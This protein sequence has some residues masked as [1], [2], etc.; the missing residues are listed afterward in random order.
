MNVQLVTVSI[1]FRGA[2]KGSPWVVQISHKHNTAYDRNRYLTSLHTYHSSHLHTAASVVVILVCLPQASQ[3]HLYT[4]RLESTKQGDGLWKL[5]L[6]QHGA[7]T[8]SFP[9]E[10]GSLHTK[11][12]HFQ[13]AL[14]F[15][16]I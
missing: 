8:P 9:N 5:Q 10:N 3:I 11:H 14:I 7:H 13:N 12:H 6:C 4:L 1:L 16:M 15:H 2:A